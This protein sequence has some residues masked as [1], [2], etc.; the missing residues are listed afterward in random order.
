M[1]VRTRDLYRAF[2]SDG[3]GISVYMGKKRPEVMFI[4]L[5][6]AV[7]CAC[8]AETADNSEQIWF[9]SDDG[10]VYQMEKGRSFDG[11]PVA[12]YLRLP[13]NH[14][15]GP[16]VIKRW[17]KVALEYDAASDISLSLSG[18][19]DNANPDQPVIAEQTLLGFGGGGFWGSVNWD[20]FYWSAPVDG[21]A[22]A[23]LDA[24]GKNMSLLLGGESADEEP[25]TLQGIT[26]SYTVR[27]A[28]R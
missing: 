3:L 11:D 24:L 14:M 1:R 8:S 2:W 4:D 22:I 27:G 13:F 18:E 17:H 10:M 12:Y 21:E 16:N 5:G 20:Q 9:G 25:H 15:G 6:R 19:V 23:Y 26:L 28:I 7:T